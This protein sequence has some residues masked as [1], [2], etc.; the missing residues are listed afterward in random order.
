[1]AAVRSS[2]LSLNDHG[3]L[4][5]AFSLEPFE[6][7]LETTAGLFTYEQ[8]TGRLS[9]LVLP[10]VSLSSDAFVGVGLGPTITN[11]AAVA[12]SGLVPATVGP[13]ADAGVGTGLFVRDAANRMLRL[14]EPGS[15]APGGGIFDWVAYPSAN[16]AGLVVFMG[17]RVDQ[18]LCP[19][20]NPDL[21][22]FDSGLYAADS[23]T[24]EVQVR[25]IPGE[26]S[27]DG[28]VFTLAAFPHLNRRGDVAFLAR[29]T[30]HPDQF[31]VFLRDR[32]GLTRVA[33]AGD[34]APGGGRFVR[35]GPGSLGTNPVQI[36][37]DGSVSFLAQLDSDVDGDGRLD[38]G[39]FQSSQGT[40]VAVARTGTEVP[41]V[42]TIRDVR[43]A[44][45][46]AN[47]RGDVVFW[48]R[49]QDGR[50]VLLLATPTA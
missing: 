46:V 15:P 39:A 4:A 27:P 42:G 20:P 32:D 33:I 18:G 30:I 49:L 47:D 50:E 26:A 7:P 22:C 17:H 9:A 14:V 44:D 25:V 43:R 40:L 38:T 31:G 23:A 6:I 34:A 29:T 41:G 35:L 3:D 36:G 5:F 10:G 19:P 24:G 28:G 8:R 16:E 37:D 21:F 12:F 1:L 2:P 13:G 45:I 11:R 48:S